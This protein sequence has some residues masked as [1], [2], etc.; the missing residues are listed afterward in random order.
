M[1]VTNPYFNHYTA[2]NEQNLIQDMVDETIYTQ[3]IGVYYIEKTQ[4]NVDFL[5]NEDATARY[6]KF[7]Q[8]AMYPI[9]VDGFDGSETMTMFGDEFQK[10]GTFVVSKRKFAEVFSF[11]VPREGDLIYL[12]IVNAILE[13]K[14]VDKESP[15]FE[16]GKQYVF[17]VKTQAY[18]H[19]H[20]EFDVQDEPELQSV[21]D[22]IGILSGQYED[23]AQN[24]DIQEEV[25]ESI[26]FDPT[27][28]FGVR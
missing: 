6:D 12:P 22:S 19:S 3:G 10:S 9:F 20:Q 28:P 8:I 17:Q 14:H 25:E 13:I 23:S 4:D 18:E 26:N 16:K 7:G 27:N 1:S 11:P 21:F 15:F 2:Q 5:F 24:E